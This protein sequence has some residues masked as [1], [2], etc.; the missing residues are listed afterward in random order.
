MNIG[1]AERVVRIV[2]GVVLLSCVLLI[3]NGVRWAGLLGLLPLV[4]GAIGW[5]PF[6]AVLSWL[7]LD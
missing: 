6:Y 4:T 2:L 5:C 1:F 7:T 3:S